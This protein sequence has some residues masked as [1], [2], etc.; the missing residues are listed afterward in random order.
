[1]YNESPSHQLKMYEENVDTYPHLNPQPT[2]KDCPALEHWSDLAWLGMT[3]PIVKAKGTDYNLALMHDKLKWNV[4]NLR[5]ILRAS[6]GN[7]ETLGVL[8]YV[9]ALKQGSGSGRDWKIKPF[10]ERIDLDANSNEGKAIIGTPNGLGVAWLLIQHK[11][12]LGEK[13]I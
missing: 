6:V 1:M 7:Y 11:Q 2:M 4:Q 10:R 9:A 8:Y 3:N 5:Y 13:R 12:D